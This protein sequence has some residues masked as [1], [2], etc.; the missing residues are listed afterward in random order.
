MYIVTAAEMRNIDQ[1]T[2]ETYRV[3][4][5]VLMEN[6][7]LQL[8]RFM[9]DHFPALRHQRVTILTGGGNNG[10]DGFILARH[11]WQKGIQVDVW[12]LVAS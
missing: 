1:R 7:G 2:I 11:L 12:L 8:L 3:P 9:Q 4:G 10:G 6:A 5:I